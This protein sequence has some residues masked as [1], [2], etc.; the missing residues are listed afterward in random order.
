MKFFHVV[1]PSLFSATF[2]LFSLLLCEA[3]QASPVTVLNNNVAINDIS[4]EVGKSAH[5]KFEVPIGLTHSS[6]RSFATRNNTSLTFHLSGGT[7]DGDIYVRLGGSPDT[8]NYLQRSIGDG[9]TE[10]ITITAPHPGTYYLTLKAVQSVQHA[11]LIA[12]YQVT[13]NSSTQLVPHVPVFNTHLP[14]PD[15]PAFW[16][17]RRRRSFC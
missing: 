3:A 17:N 6:F 2:F 5:F 15:I 8:L 12:N 7:G 16:R 11:S 4:L 9:N 1:T 14:T 10:I 13:L